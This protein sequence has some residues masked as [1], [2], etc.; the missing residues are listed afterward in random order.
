MS[1]DLVPFDP[2]AIES[3]E[4]AAA[5]V[6]NALIE[7]KAWLA[8]AVTRTDP[9][10]IA[11]FKAWAATVAEATRQKGLAEEIQLDATE[12]VRRAERGIGVAIRNGQSAG[13][14]K[15]Q[16]QGG[17]QPPHSQRPR[18]DSDK[19]AP[20]DFASNSELSGNHTGIYSITDGVTDERFEQAIADAKDERNLSRANVSRHAH[21]ES[22]APRSANRHELLNNTRRPN[23]NRIVEETVTAL[24]GLCIGLG[25][26]DYDE[27]DITKAPHWAASLEESM[28][29][30]R[31]FQK[32]LNR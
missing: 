4:D 30:L 26:V 6:T 8:V 12:M 14:I 21:G 24:E 19:L 3:A 32:E 29:A 16:G 9:T 13:V 31:R 2:A 5:L 22:R 7:S 25:L 1:T 15:T 18:V 11:E 23:T 17:G 10:P 28:K 20:T 27:L